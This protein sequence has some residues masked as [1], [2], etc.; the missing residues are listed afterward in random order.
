M[1]F[2]KK[3]FGR[4]TGGTKVGN[5]FRGFA[6]KINKN[7]GTG[8]NM[9]VDDS[10]QVA[11]NLQNN[12]ATQLGGEAGAFLTETIAHTVAQGVNNASPH[13]PVGQVRDVVQQIADKSAENIVK[14]TFMNTLKKYWYIPVIIVV[15]VIVWIFKAKNKSRR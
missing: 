9:K 10:T 8:K 5:F 13:T 12:S 15:G 7:W 6:N 1:G 4:K 2:L 11:I 14:N 3:M